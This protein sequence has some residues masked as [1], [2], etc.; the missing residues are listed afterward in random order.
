MVSLLECIFAAEAYSIDS[1]LAVNLFLF[2]NKCNDCSVFISYP[3]S[4]DYNGHVLLATTVQDDPLLF[5]V[6]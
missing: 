2:R 3:C 5:Q 1:N 4:Q 6:L